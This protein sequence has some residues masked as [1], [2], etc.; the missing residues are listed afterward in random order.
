MKTNEKISREHLLYLKGIK[1]R[2]I[3]INAIRIAIFV[4]FLMIWEL[5]YRIGL[6]DGFIFSSPSRIALSLYALASLGELIKHSAI[7]LY[8]TLLGFI[9]ASAGGTLI[10]L[11]MWFNE[12]VRKIAEPYLVVLN[13]LPKIA[14][15]PLI[16]IWFGSGRTA[17]VVM[18]VLIT[19]IVTVITMLAGFISTDE[20]K[21]LLMKTLGANKFQ[22]LAK[23][24]LPSSIPAFISMLKINIGLSWIGSIMGEYLVSEAGIGYLIVYGGQVF[25]LDLVYASTLVLCILA[26]GMYALVSL[27]ER[28]I[29][30]KRK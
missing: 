29:N 30:S 18:A 7:T 27:A 28:K 21:I 2:A 6:T 10:A 8:E 16:I 25:R 24:V 19:V 26:T 14:L 4:I 15:G 9:I 23:L 20:N 3:K 17:I 1:R 11:L 5:S 12:T 22:I 13:S